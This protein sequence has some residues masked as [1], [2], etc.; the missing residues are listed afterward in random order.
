VKLALNL[1]EERS[2]AAGRVKIVGIED[3]ILTLAIEMEA[4]LPRFKNSSNFG[5]FLA[6]EDQSND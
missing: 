6:V 2:R 1:A 3:E 5:K 4:L